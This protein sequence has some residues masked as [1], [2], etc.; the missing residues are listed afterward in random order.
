MLLILLLLLGVVVLGGGGFALYYYTSNRPQQAPGRAGAASVGRSGTGLWG[1]A[2]GA[3][4]RLWNNAEDE[5][6]EYYDD[7]DDEYYDDEYDEYEEDEWD[8]DEEMWEESGEYYDPRTRRS[9]GPMTGA[10]PATGTGWGNPNTGRGGVARPPTQPR[11]Q[12]PQD[13]NPWPQSGGTGYQ[14]PPQPP[15]SRPNQY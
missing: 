6:D 14:R 13:D 2:V 7:E 10:G 15:K 11:Q 4:G 5:D 12:Y 3:V 1:G 9:G 8:G